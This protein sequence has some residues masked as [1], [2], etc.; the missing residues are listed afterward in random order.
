ML[1]KHSVLLSK[2]FW[3]Y[4]KAYAD[5]IEINCSTTIGIDFL[6]FIVL[7]STFHKYK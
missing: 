3:K 4:S 5:Q 7:L 2:V 6:H 1:H